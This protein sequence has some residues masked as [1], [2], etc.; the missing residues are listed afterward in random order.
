MMW[1]SVIA[2]P[3]GLILRG[4]QLVACRPSL[5][6]LSAACVPYVSA[7]LLLTQSSARFPRTLLPTTIVPLMAAMLGE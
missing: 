3:R 1:H 2:R 7:P 4:K 5:L 6:L